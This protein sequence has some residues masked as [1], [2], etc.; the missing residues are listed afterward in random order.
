MGDPFPKEDK[1]QRGSQSP[2]LSRASSC[3]WTVP[4]SLWD[5]GITRSGTHMRTCLPNKAAHLTV[6]QTDSD[7]TCSQ[8]HKNHKCCKCLTNWDRPLFGFRPSTVLGQKAS[9]KS[10]LQ[11][12]CG[13]NMPGRIRP[14]PTGGPHGHPAVST[15]LKPMG[16]AEPGG[17]AWSLALFCTTAGL[18]RACS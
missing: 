8:P 14:L 4:L 9:L 15:V 10:L 12:L 1:H 6:A 11:E 17:Q 3:S 18:D 2:Q 13:Q 16:K 5:R 7:F